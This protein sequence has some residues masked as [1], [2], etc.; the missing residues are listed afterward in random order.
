MRLMVV[1]VD[2]EEYLKQYPDEMVWL[3][4]KTREL[5]LKMEPG[6]DE[7]IRW[8][9]LTYGNKKMLIALVIHQKY[10]NMEFANGRELT[11]IGYPL[12]GTG[13]NIRHLKIR[14]G[15]DLESEIIPELIRKSI[16]LDLNEK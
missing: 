1:R 13:K 4:M 2:V 14:T 15:E 6:L 12:E 5:I 10:L 7:K 8:K 9:N 11:K 16:E 3:V